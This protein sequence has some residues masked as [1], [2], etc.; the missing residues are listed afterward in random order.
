MLEAS[1]L[2]KRGRSPAE[3]TVLKEADHTWYS[4][5]KA[6]EVFRQIPQRNMMIRTDLD[7]PIHH[8]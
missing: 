5:R 3:G 1:V 8:S 2:W 7:E 6:S 4:S